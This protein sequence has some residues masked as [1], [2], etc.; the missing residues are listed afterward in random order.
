MPFGGAVVNHVLAGRKLSHAIAIPIGC[1]ASQRMARNR[2]R[3]L[4]DTAYHPQGN[5]LAG[6]ERLVAGNLL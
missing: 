4:D 5:V 2:D 3:S 1:N 6:F